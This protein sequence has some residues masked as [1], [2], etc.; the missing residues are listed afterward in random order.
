MS[1]EKDQSVTFDFDLNLV[2]N[3]SFIGIGIYCA[4][5]GM[6]EAG[7]DLRSSIAALEA[8]HGKITVSNGLNELYRNKL[9]IIED[10]P[11][12]TKVD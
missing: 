1:K 9:L 12:D 11:R 5:A 6:Q 7:I 2:N 10:E 8:N 3:L 4:L